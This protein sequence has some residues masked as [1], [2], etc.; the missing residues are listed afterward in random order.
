[1]GLFSAKNGKRS[2][3]AVRKS[4]AATQIEMES[5]SK[6]DI[7]AT[8]GILLGI[9]IRNFNLQE[10]NMNI[11]RRVVNVIAERIVA[12][13]GG[14]ISARVETFVILEETEQRNELE[15]RACQLEEEGKPQLAAVLRNRVGKLHADQPAAQGF[16]I[17]EQ[18]QADDFPDWRLALLGHQTAEDETPST[19]EPISSLQKTLDRRNRRSG[20]KDTPPDAAQVP[21]TASASRQ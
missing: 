10:K 1:M 11:L 7:L 8:N 14:M 15:N 13:V 2:S 4:Q 3:E 9:G 12:L 20:R 19:E 5:I 17:I 18:L 21:A 16:R 6:K